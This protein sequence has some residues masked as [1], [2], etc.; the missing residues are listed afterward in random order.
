MA[1]ATIDDAKTWVSRLDIGASTD[2][3]DAELGDML[4]TVEG[5]INTF[6]AAHGVETPF[7]SDGTDEQDEFTAY[8]QGLSAR[9]TAAA[10]L[11]SLAGGD[12][13]TGPAEWLVGEYQADLEDLKGGALLPTWLAQP[14]DAESTTP[15][16]SASSPTG[17]GYFK[18]F[19]NGDRR[20]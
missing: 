6:L 1:Y 13:L 12:S 5:K 11:V 4:V 8:L 14:D 18:R 3:S 10:A 15:T 20:V 19:A 2:L 7:A 17:G 16:F 9:G